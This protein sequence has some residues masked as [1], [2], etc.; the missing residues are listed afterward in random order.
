MIKHIINKSIPVGGMDKSYP[1]KLGEA[2]LLST[3][4]YQYEVPM[5]SSRKKS[6]LPKLHIYTETSAEVIDT[7]YRTQT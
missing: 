5:A 4:P 3:K 2:C 7:D 6:Q 1:I